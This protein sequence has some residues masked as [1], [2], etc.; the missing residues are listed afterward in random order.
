MQRATAIRAAGTWS[1]AATDSVVL[2]YDHR[3]RRRLLM[4]GTNGLQFLLDLPHAA[5]LRHGDAL[6]LDDGR[7]IVVQSAAED[8]MEIEGCDAEHR[9]RLA[10]HL[11]NRHLPTQL[12]GERMRIRDDQVIADMLVGLGATVTRVSAPFQPEGGAYGVAMPV[13]GHGHLPDEKAP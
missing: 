4:T 1:G 2:D 11:G 5:A 9:A 13:H 12:L 3:R 7:L 10:W 8:L 6:A